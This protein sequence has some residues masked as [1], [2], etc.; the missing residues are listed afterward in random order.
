MPSVNAAIRRLRLGPKTP[1][2]LGGLL[3]PPVE[4][5]FQM[6]QSPSLKP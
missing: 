2:V 3:A 4:R 5:A 6:N 1:R